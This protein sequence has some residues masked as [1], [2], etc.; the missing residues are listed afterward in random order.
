MTTKKSPFLNLCEQLYQGAMSLGILFV[1]YG[2]FSESLGKTASVSSSERALGLAVLITLSAQLL[3]AL[4]KEKNLKLQ[5]GLGLLGLNVVAFLYSLKF[6]ESM[7]SFWLYFWIEAVSFASSGAVCLIRRFFVLESILILAQGASLVVLAVLEKPV[8]VWCVGIMLGEFLLFLVSL[9]AKDKKEVLGLMPFFAAAALILCLN[10]RKEEPMDW[11]WAKEAYYSIQD[12]TWTI[13]LDVAYI[14]KEQ[15]DFSLSGY[16][17][18]RKLGGIV[19]DNPRDTLYISGNGTKNPLYLTGKTYNVYTGTEWE[20]SPDLPKD[21]ENENILKAI[22]QSVFAEKRREIT[23]YCLLTVE[24]RFIKTADF[25]HELNTT[26]VYGEIPPLRD[27][28]PWTFEKPQKKGLHYQLHFLEI[29]PKSEEIKTLLRGGAWAENERPDKGTEDYRRSIYKAYTEL[30]DSLPDRVYALARSI[31]EGADND[32]DKMQAFAE[33]LRSY[34]Y[35]ETPSELPEGQDFADS[36]LFDGKEGY[37]AYFATAMA[38]LGRCE[39]IPTRYVQGFMTNDTCRGAVSDAVINE[40]QAHAW[41]EFYIERV[42][43][44][45]ID[46]TPGYGESPTDRWAPKGSSGGSQIEN[47]NFNPNPPK[48]DGAD[49]PASPENPTEE[50]AVPKRPAVWFAVLKIALAV[51]AAVAFVVLAVFLR[52][53]IRRIK[54]E[55]ADDLTKAKIQLKRLLLLGRLK[56]VSLLDGETLEAYGERAKGV[57]TGEGCSFTVACEIYE[58]A[59]FG[60][61]PISKAELCRLE[62]YADSV[63]QSYLESCGFF[64]KIIYLNIVMYR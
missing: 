39:G 61:K 48:P 35:N 1:I 40:T 62:K 45:R 20:A 5:F 18:A 19:A 42:G 11:T 4:A 33:Y 14:F 12:R 30:P 7:D 10:V 34:T 26:D 49:T 52:R 57:L 55:K 46:A 23:S 60:E 43:W 50:V 25:F 21:S 6:A 44:V 2:F 41:T 59:R 54:Y 9:G 53:L 31:S 47:P 29:N 38:V 63:W 22:E 64:K 28:L 56:G 58:K 51:L 37:C 27:N 3:I 15:N 32:Y 8:P 13:A 24:Y 16:G 17:E 36:F